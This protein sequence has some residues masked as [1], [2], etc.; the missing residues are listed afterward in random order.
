MWLAL[1]LLLMLLICVL[2]FTSHPPGLEFDQADKV[3]HLAAFMALAVCAALALPPGWGSDLAVWVLMLGFGVFIE[4]VQMHL[5]SRSA[6]W[7]DVVAD[8]A[9]ALLGLLAV[10]A[11][12]RI[13]PRS[14]KLMR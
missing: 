10:A 9:G 6:D 4:A 1:L 7:Q 13:K 2:A 8:L 3:Q 14:Q 5:P 12:R 11:A